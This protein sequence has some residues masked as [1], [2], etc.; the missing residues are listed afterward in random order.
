MNLAIKQSTL[1]NGILFAFFMSLFIITGCSKDDDNE[2]DA[3]PSFTATLDW[4]DGVTSLEGIEASNLPSSISVTWADDLTQIDST[5]LVADSERL[6]EI[7]Y[8]ATSVEDGQTVNVIAVNQIVGQDTLLLNFS[9]YG[10]LLEAKR[11]PIASGA[12]LLQ[13]LECL[14]GCEDG[15]DLPEGVA[16]PILY[17]SQY[18]EFSLF[19]L[20]GGFDYG[21]DD[22][23]EFDSFDSDNR[24]S[25]SFKMNMKFAEDT[26]IEEGVSVSNMPVLK[27]ENGQFNKVPEVK[28]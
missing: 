25:G 4:Q 16:I 15:L 19:G 13:I 2:A 14:F 6:P 3:T 23:I 20:L 7:A 21:A 22:Y 24:A 18:E 11:Y 10:E 8:W 1:F 17:M 5:L 9:I 26:E 27:I 12:I 28:E